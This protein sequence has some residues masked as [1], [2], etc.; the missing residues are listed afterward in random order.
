MSKGAHAL[1]G[2]ADPQ[3]VFVAAHAAAAAEGFQV[4]E[5]SSSLG[6]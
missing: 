1:R 3:E 5:E 4:S 2:I 6:A